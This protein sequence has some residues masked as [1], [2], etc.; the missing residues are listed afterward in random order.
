LIEV[1]TEIII[2]NGYMRRQQLYKSTCRLCGNLS[3]GP[4][5][6]DDPPRSTTVGCEEHAWRQEGKRQRAPAKHGVGSVPS[7]LVENV[8]H[9]QRQSHTATQHMNL[10]KSPTITDNVQ[11]VSATV[12]Q[13]LW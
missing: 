1:K 8:F 2:I 3:V 4:R 13:F 7:V 12:K 6:V 9:C 11:N 10:T 5:I